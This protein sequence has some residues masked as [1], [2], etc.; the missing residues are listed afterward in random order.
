MTAVAS[1]DATADNFSES[2][3]GTSFTNLVVAG[4]K[5]DAS[6]PDNTVITLPGLGSVTVKAVSGNSGKKKE[7]LFVGVL[8]IVIT[9]ANA[10]GLP[11]G[12]KLVIAEASAG[13][14]RFQPTTALTGS[15]SGVVIN[16]GHAGGDVG[17]P[18]CSGTDGVTKTRTVSSL[19]VAN[20]VSADTV[21]STAFGA[22][23]GSALVA[24]TSATLS[25]VTL[26]KGLI[27]AKSLSA[28]AQESRTGTVSTA[29][30]AGSGFEQLTIAGIPVD[31]ATPPNTTIKLPA[32]GY[33]VVNEQIQQRGAR[34]V[35]EALHVLVEPTSSSG[36]R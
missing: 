33:V 3:A 6:V 29:S 11:L 9:Q 28:V 24:K 34:L 10:F 23:V 35:V 7:K 8:S 19:D 17:L 2:D 4:T 32:L 14:S 15:A 31:S 13:Y 1:V 36:V 18:G 20:I 26:L 30:S 16:G 27:T 21:T 12:A 25:N 22:P 5:V